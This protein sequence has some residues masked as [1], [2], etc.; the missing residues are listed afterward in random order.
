MIIH[1]YFCSYLAVRLQSAGVVS[2]VFSKTSQRSRDSRSW[3]SDG[4]FFAARGNVFSMRYTHIHKR[5]KGVFTCAIRLRHEI[6]RVIIMPVTFP[7]SWHWPF[8]GATISTVGN[9][10]F[11]A[12]VPRIWNRLP[13]DVVQHSIF[14]ASGSK[15]SLSF[16]NHF[17]TF[18]S[19]CFPCRFVIII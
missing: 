19:D 2:V 18:Y 15:L 5:L 10:A 6:L 7:F 9:G 17:R 1:Y 3:C 12:A 16:V 4:D 13:D 11:L 14:S 8:G